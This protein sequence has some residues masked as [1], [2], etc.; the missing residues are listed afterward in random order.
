MY[1]EYLTAEAVCGT[2]RQVLRL[3]YVMEILYESS[4][5]LHSLYILPPTVSSLQKM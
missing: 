2:Q 5:C 3:K 4:K 1:R